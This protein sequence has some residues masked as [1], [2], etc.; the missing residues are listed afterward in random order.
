[1]SDIENSVLDNL[2]TLSEKLPANK[3][4]SIFEYVDKIGQYFDDG[5]F[6]Q[7]NLPNQTTHKYVNSFIESILKLV[8]IYESLWICIN[9]VFLKSL[10]GCRKQVLHCDYE[11]DFLQAA[12]SWWIFWLPWVTRNIFHWK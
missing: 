8:H 11:D 4:S 5:T 12:D 10:P 9:P 6:I 2:T 3:W 1:M 7:A